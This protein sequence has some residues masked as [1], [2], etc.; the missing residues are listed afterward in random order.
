[1]FNVLVIGESCKDVFVYGN[2]GRL[3]PEAPAPVFV[4]D[5]IVETDG[6]ALNVYHNLKA[7]GANVD[8]ITNNSWHA[9]TKTRYIDK[10]INYMFLRVDENDDK[11]TVFKDIDSID[12]SLYDAVAIA[13][14]NK[15]FLPIKTMQ[16]IKSKHDLVFLDTKKK[17]GNWINSVATFIKVNEYEYKTSDKLS[18]AAKG[19]VI[20]TMGAR[21]AHHKNVTY[22][23]SQVKIK[24]LSGAGDTFMSGLIMKYLKTD[25]I[26]EAI[27]FANECAT[28]V[29]T[30]AGV[31]I[32]N[33]EELD[34]SM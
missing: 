29:V 22:P 6:M 27:R 19:K 5:H 12:F 30:K 26:A 23:V 18:K 24:D 16:K 32:V 8:I 28:N 34:E 33:V 31:S 2:S 4:P 17:L 21:G 25:S 10:K 1:M 3:A 20:V 15:G 13:D 11:Y 7:L 9:I 14:Y